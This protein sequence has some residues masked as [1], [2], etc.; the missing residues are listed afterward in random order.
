MT[1]GK[2][3][4]MRKPFCYRWDMP[5]VPSLVPYSGKEALIVVPKCCFPS[6]M[7]S[8]LGVKNQRLFARA[9]ISKKALDVTSSCCPNGM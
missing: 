9:S 8:Y 4:R 7:Q 6:M 2:K 3:L 1:S 5:E